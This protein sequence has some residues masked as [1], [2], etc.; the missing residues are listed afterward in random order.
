MMMSWLMAPA[1]GHGNGRPHRKD[2]HYLRLSQLV[3]TPGHA[4]RDDTEAP[5]RAMRG[6][7]ALPPWPSVSRRRG[8]PAWLGLDPS[9]LAGRCLGG[10]SAFSP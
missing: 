2:G 1:N 3:A 4:A 6:G 8:R 5:G 7:E 10:F 9:S